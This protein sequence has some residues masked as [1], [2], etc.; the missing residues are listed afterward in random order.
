MRID[1][2]PLLAGALLLLAV[3]AGLALRRRV[4]RRRLMRRRRAQAR[5]PESA[6]A[7]R[8]ARAPPSAAPPDAPASLLD[9]EAFHGRL[10]ERSRHPGSLPPPLLTLTL[11]P[12][13]AMH[14]RLGLVGTER[15]LATVAALLADYAAQVPGS[16]AGR[17]EAGGFALLLPVPGLERDTAASLDRALHAALQAASIAR[18]AWPSWTVAAVGAHPGAGG[19]G[20]REPQAISPA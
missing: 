4:M 3:L 5:A 20:T 9:A 1:V 11:G 2:A 18:S 12:L 8:A 7:A 13:P 15:L 17:L 10:R 19:P 6:G 14:E 16:V